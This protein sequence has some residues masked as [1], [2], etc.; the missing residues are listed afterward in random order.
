MLK[1][2]KFRALVAFIT[3][4]CF[5][6]NTYAV[7]PMVVNSLYNYAH[8]KQVTKIR[9]MIKNMGYD[10]DV[11]DEDGNTAWCI[12]KEKNDTCAMSVLE[13]FGADIEQRC[14]L[15]WGWIGAA[16]G[17]AAIG[18]VAAAV[19]GGGGGGSDPCSGVVC[20]DNQHCEKGTCICN[21]GY[22]DTEGNGVCYADLHCADQE[23]SIGVQHLNQCVCKDGLWSGKS[24]DVCSGHIGDN[25]YCYEKLNCWH[26]GEQ[27]ND[28]CDCTN[29]NG[30]S[31]PLC[32]ECNG[33]FI[34]DD[35]VCYPDLSCQHGGKQVN[36]TCD[37]SVTNGYTGQY[38]ELCEDG[39]DQNN[40]C[41]EKIDCGQA[42]GRGHQN[43][44]TCVCDNG[45]SGTDQACGVCDGFEGNDGV[46]YPEQ[47]CN[48][49]HGHQENGGCVCDTTNGYTGSN[50]KD[51]ASGYGHYGS[52]TE[53]YPTLDCGEHGT[54]SYGSCECQ[55]GWAGEFCDTCDTDNGYYEENGTCYKDLDCEN[56][57]GSTG[58]QI[59]NQCECKEGYSGQLCNTCANG[60]DH[61]FGAPYCYETIDC[62][63]NGYQNTDR[64]V[65]LNGWE[66]EFC[67]EC[68][69]G[70]EG[71]DGLCYPA[72][73][74]GNGHQS[75][76]T[77]ICDEGYA[78]DGT[79]KCVGKEA[80]KFAIIENNNY[81]QAEDKVVTN[82]TY[83][84]LIGKQYKSVESEASDSIL[85]EPCDLYTHIL[86]NEDKA[87]RHNQE[88]TLEIR[89]YTDG[90]VYGVTSPDARDM[91]VTYLWLSNSVE[92]KSQQTTLIE[93]SN[94]YT[95][96]K[97][98]YT[99]IT[100]GD[101]D[102]FGIYAP[103]TY[104]DTGEP[105]DI[106]NI[107]KNISNDVTYDYDFSSTVKVTSLG[108]GQSFG[109]YSQ[110]GNINNGLYDVNTGANS[111]TDA[112]V[113][114]VTN[115]ATGNAY[116]LY[117]ASNGNILNSG[118]VKVETNSGLAIG[119][120]SNG[121]SIT[122]SGKVN[123]KSTAGTAIGIYANGGSVTNSGTITVNGTEG[124][125]FGIYATNG[126]TVSNTGRIVLNGDTYTGNG[127][128]G[129]GDHI[130]LDGAAV[131]KNFGLTTANYDIDFDETDGTTV[132]GKGGAFKATSLSGTLAVDNS[133]VNDGFEDKYVENQALQS[134]NVNVNLASNSAMF[135][136]SVQKDEG[137]DS[138]SVVMTRKSFEELSASSSIA[139]FLE[140]NYQAKNNEALFSELKKAGLK[141]YASV[142]AKALGYGLIPN[143]A[144]ENMS[145]LRN[146]NT[147]LNDEL[148]EPA[149]S[150]RQIVG[151]DYLYQGRDTK[152]SLTGYENYA[153]TMYFMFDKEHDNLVRSGIGMSITQFNSDYDDDSSR[154]D[155][156]IQGLIPVSYL[157]DNGMNYASIARFGYSDGEYER[158]GTNGKFES[159]LTSWIYGLSNA[160]RYKID[161]GYVI[162]EPS[163]EFNILG[164]YQN[165]I[166]EDKGKQNA[167]K[168]DAENNLSVEAGI[169]LN[170]SKDVKISDKSKL[171]FK[172]GAMYYHEFAHPYHSLEASIHGTDGTYRIT[173]Y[174]GIYDRDRGVLSAGIDYSY[175]PFTFYGKLKAFIE[176]E[177]PFEANAGIKYNF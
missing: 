17:V 54:Q 160:A 135:E 117:A 100:G 73:E 176:D 35:D 132:L 45:W 19:G 98:G 130:V 9:Y 128:S 70:R 154:K 90:N 105:T 140:K 67:N 156:M 24:C 1:N 123:V 170:I 29:A 172:L 38:C 32:N 139:E 110:Y 86:V 171:N 79:G 92:E 175:K 108:S 62:G 113:V 20:G 96:T 18:G 4:M 112:A 118:V 21:A 131:Y 51:C 120:Y 87:T 60:Y 169:G 137:T 81:I 89:Q 58:T 85:G 104:F 53:C 165:R 102:A 163:A 33:G 41:W 43:E 88:L 150:E 164:Y 166:R 94:G 125:S 7:S 99:Y 83:S 6:F 84:D 107:A 2:S 82:T 15:P 46:C 36:G 152:G 31:G 134:A 69:A 48:E 157:D 111:I 80:A 27:K 74:C 138:S 146:L 59:N 30:W 42:L 28:S 162:L 65:C 11:E 23:H 97:D 55:L 68:P 148:F 177:Y 14:G 56:Y 133:V 64:C 124:D 143:F 122:N 145:V 115:T 71:A 119:L 10:I 106:Y 66:G 149:G 142:E 91:Y 129:Y 13:Q 37:C 93:I 39:W 75:G 57:P 40:T 167:I 44:N 103:G 16:A 151:Y 121:G 76:N 174:E 126:A 95:Y 12:A 161:L 22:L 52:E 155:L 8:T 114:E 147:V 136:A 72:I 3:A 49:P 127:S 173:D 153:N 5:S 61:Y 116:G 168:A 26:G 159:D 78:R 25:D 101:G 77:C 158:Y 50:C 63:T 141:S 47:Q 109:M 34:G 144:H